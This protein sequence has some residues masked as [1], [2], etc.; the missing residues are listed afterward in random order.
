MNP[1]TKQKQNRG[2]GEQA[3]GH[4]GA[5]LAESG[6]GRWGQQAQALDAERMNS[7]VLA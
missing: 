2:H 3:G 4:Q 6:T 5:E 1:T 7:K